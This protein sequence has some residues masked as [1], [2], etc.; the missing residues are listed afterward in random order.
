VTIAGC[1]RTIR[2]MGTY[3]S[4]EVFA[5]ES[6]HAEVVGFAVDRAFGWFQHIEQICSRFDPG[7]ELSRLTRTIGEP[8]HVSRLLYEAVE[9]AVAVA[10]ESSGAFDPTVGIDME[11]RGFDREYRTGDTVRTDGHTS[12][13][14]YRDI[15][16]DGDGRR[17]TL[18]RALMLDLGAVVKGLAIDL[19]ARELAP[20]ENFVVDAGGDLFV[21]GR[22]SDGASWK[23]GIRHPRRDG[24]LIDAVSVSDAAVCTSGDY[25]RRIGNN[26]IHH[27]I[28]GRTRTTAHLLASATVIAPS[29]MVADGL[30]TAAFVLGPDDGIRLLERQGVEGLL[31]TP[32][33]E[34]HATRG[35]PSDSSILQDAQ[36]P[37][38]DCSRPVAGH[39]RPHR[40][41]QPDLDSPD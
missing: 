16:L 23:V 5:G 9:F 3:A 8:V 13:V 24:A 25:E 36:G 1:A 19:A 39:R 29:A 32:G 17:I 40:G 2:V 41:S 22:R 31:I 27:I 26:G 35:F 30:A 6:N 38:D 37:S 14:W 34:R 12:P 15:V 4:I 33:L 7:S 21:A 20:F 10:E 18:L 28:D 11:R